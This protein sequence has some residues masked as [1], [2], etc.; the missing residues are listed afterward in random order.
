MS[1]NLGKYWLRQNG[2][3]PPSNKERWSTYDLREILDELLPKYAGLKGLQM[4]DI[5][6]ALET[7]TCPPNLK[8]FE[9][10]LVVLYAEVQETFDK[11]HRESQTQVCDYYFELDS[12]SEVDTS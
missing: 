7:N 12:D 5:V 10:D 6:H 11:D 3:I 2:W 4:D 1:T 9:K 8:K